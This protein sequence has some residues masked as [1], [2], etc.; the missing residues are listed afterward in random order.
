MSRFSATTFD[1][2]IEP[3]ISKS[4]SNPNIESNLERQQSSS[5]DKRNRRAYISPALYATPKATPLPDCPSSFIPSP[6][7]VNHKRRGPRL[8][9]SLSH[10]NV[11][12]CQQS[13]E[14][15]KPSEDGTI[16]GD[17]AYPLAVPSSNP[18]EQADANGFHDSKLQVDGSGDGLVGGNESFKTLPRDPVEGEDFF[19]PQDSA[20][21]ET[22][23]DDHV[24]I[25]RSWKPT[26]PYGEYFDACEELSYDGTPLSFRNNVEEDLWEMKL[27]LLMEIEKRKQAEEALNKILEQWQRVARQLSQVGLTLPEASTILSEKGDLPDAGPVEELCQ[28]VVLARAV[29]NAIGRGVAKAEV[30][31]EMESHIESKNFEITRLSDRLH[32][33]EAMNHEMSQR[34]QQAVGKKSTATT[35]EKEKKADMDLEFNWHCHYTRLSSSCMVVP[36]KF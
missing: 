27:H 6:Y 7:V 13:K 4:S 35:T 26:T 33:Y 14:K 10:N 24:G 29:A 9:K 3:K 15:E 2:L 17:G 19:D 21:V 25:G 16:A 5:T 11:I 36:T 22:E 32:I 34:N 28:Q 23:T 18:S 20:S 8:L 12:N 1:R 30:E 31:L